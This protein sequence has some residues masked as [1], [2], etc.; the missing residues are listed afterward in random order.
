MSKK[1]QD[2]KNLLSDVVV[3]N[4][5]AKYIKKLKRRETWEEIVY[6]YLSMM[7]SQ[8]P[9]LK[10]DIWKEGNEILNKKVL[11]SMRALQFAGPAAIKN[12]ARLYNCSYLPIDD[13]RG[14]SEAMFLLLSGTG[15]GFSVQNK[16]IS[17]LPEITKPTKEYRYLVGDSIEGWAD[18]VRHLVASYFGLRGTKPNFD[19]S[20]IREKGEELVTSGGKAPGPEP[21][22][23]CLHQIERIL[24]SKS[25]G[26]KLR[27]IE[28]HD[29]MC[30]IANAVLAGGIRRSATISLF[31]AD[32]DEMLAC[33]AGNWWELNPQRGRAN[34]SA[35]LVRHKITKQF[36]LDLWKKIEASG[37]GEPGFYFTNNNDWGTNPC[38]EIALRPFEFCNLTELNVSNITSQEDF[39]QRCQAASFFGTLQAGFTNFH[40]LRPIW[41]K[42]CEKEALL[43][44]SMT[45]IAAG[46]IYK[47]NLE[48]G[49]NLIREVNIST[50]YSIKINPAARLTTTKPSGTASLVLGTSSGIHAYHDKYYIRRMQVIKSE[51]LYQ[52]LFDLNPKLVPDYLAIPNTAVLELP[53]KAPDNAILRSESALDLLERVKYVSEKWIKPGHISGDNTHNVS[54]TVSIDKTRTYVDA[55]TNWLKIDEWVK[56]GEWMW[57]NRD[58]YNG[59]SVL[60]YDGGTYT[61]APFESISEE[62]YNTLIKEIPHNF[63]LA[64]IVEEVDLTSLVDELACSGNNCEIQ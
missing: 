48:E 60:P 22:K 51:P 57:D 6:R 24:D 16:H 54:A 52:Y 50:A 13:Y 33:K 45:G 31:D 49:V 40:Y 59:L 2:S 41:K 17:K 37:S 23:E 44:V 3:F 11:P 56:V 21:L 27:P 5:Y 34:N 20:D 26:D 30:H 28:V 53:V 38:C 32:D 14:F 29:I 39:L 12:N 42:T 64:N 19:F 15:V 1:V 36:F 62:T 4:K 46:D 9:Q 18:A 43:G 35:V 63:N 61:Q 58:V 10:E 8:Y 55:L 7:E 25:N 47:L